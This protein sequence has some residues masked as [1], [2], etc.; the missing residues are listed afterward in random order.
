MPR[1]SWCPGAGLVFIFTSPPRKQVVQPGRRVFARTAGFWGQTP[2]PHPGA[3]RLFLDLPLTLLHSH[4]FQH[5]RCRPEGP[6]PSQQ[7][8]QDWGRA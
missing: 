2:T 8:N 7:V 5:L 1:C 3:Q 6:S 4:F